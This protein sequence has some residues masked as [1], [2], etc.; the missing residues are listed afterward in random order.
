MLIDIQKV[1]NFY[2]FCENQQ[3][4]HD[5]RLTFKT[6]ILFYGDN[7]WTVSLRQTKFG[8]M[9]DHGHIYT[10]CLSQHFLQRS[11][12][13]WRWWEFETFELDA[14]IAPLSLGP[15]NL[16]FWQIFIRWT[17]FNKTTIASKKAR[18]LRSV[19]SLNLLHSILWRQFMNR[20]TWTN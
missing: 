11:F 1:N 10:F 12:Q 14:K 15:W 7:S 6:H 8:T 13:M 9:K 18:T 2:H 20:C 17:T 5:R 4:E 19:E 3:Y 16:V